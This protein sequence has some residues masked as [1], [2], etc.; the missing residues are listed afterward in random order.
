MKIDDDL[1]ERMGTFNRRH[2]AL[3]AKFLEGHKQLCNMA[4]DGT[5]QHLK[6]S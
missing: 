4:E 5:L 1:F 2:H 3:K 6:R